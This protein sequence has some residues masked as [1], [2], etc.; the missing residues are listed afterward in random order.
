MKAITRALI[1]CAIFYLQI[2]AD[3]YVVISNKN[4]Q[5]LS[6]E[7]IKAIYL[8]KLI[9]VNDINIVPINLDSGDQLRDKFNN[10]I[11][12][13]SVSRLQ[14]HW[15]KQHYLGHRPPLSLKSQESVKA[16]VKKVDGAI[17][18]VNKKNIDDEVRVLYQWRD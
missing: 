9:I 6:A 5:I 3:E 4:A 11:L 15:T 14:T 2:N 10:E 13:M 17:G 18:Y 1:L 7:Q 8:K 12:N 16:F